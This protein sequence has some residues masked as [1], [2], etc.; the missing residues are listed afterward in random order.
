[1]RTKR[2]ASLFIGAAAVLRR[3]CDVLNHYDGLPGFKLGEN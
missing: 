1:M 2:L 3:P